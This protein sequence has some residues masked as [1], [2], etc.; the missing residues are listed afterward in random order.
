MMTEEM[1]MG[2][3]AMMGVGSGAMTTPAA[4]SSQL[5]M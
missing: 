1:M 2:E 5:F 3:A 4:P